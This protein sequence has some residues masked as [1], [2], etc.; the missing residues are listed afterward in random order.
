MARKKPAGPSIGADVC[1]ECGARRESDLG[2]ILQCPEGH[3][4][5]AGVHFCTCGKPVAVLFNSPDAKRNFDYDCPLMIVCTECLTRLGVMDR[6]Q[7]A[8]RMVGMGG[9][10]EA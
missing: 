1:L 4:F 3:G 5:C 2:R 9:E 8:G 10:N 7:P 6:S